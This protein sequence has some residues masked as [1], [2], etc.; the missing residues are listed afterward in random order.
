[1][2]QAQQNL[3]SLS[4]TIYNFKYSI[5]ECPNTISLYSLTK[6]DRYLIILTKFVYSNTFSY[7]ITIICIEFLFSNNDKVHSYLIFT[8]R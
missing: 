4:I 7:K 6:Q 1:M 5:E 8:L 2:R 3:I